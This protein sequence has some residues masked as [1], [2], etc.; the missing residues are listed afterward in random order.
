[1][2]CEQTYKHI[3]C[4]YYHH[5]LAFSTSDMHMS[6]R[7]KRIK[8]MHFGLIFGCAAYLGIRKA[9]N[10]RNMKMFGKINCN[11]ESTFR[12]NMRILLAISRYE[13][14]TCNQGPGH[15]SLKKSAAG[16]CPGQSWPRRHISPKPHQRM[17]RGATTTP[18]LSS[19]SA[20]ARPGW[21]IA[22]AW[23]YR[24]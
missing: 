7:Q 18:R 1:M 2:T 10:H 3:I 6:P 12:F 14:I 8:N 4:A 15:G 17:G 16:A 22:C 5:M 13:N 9:M 11:S 19:P 20:T 23:Q 24:L 21:R